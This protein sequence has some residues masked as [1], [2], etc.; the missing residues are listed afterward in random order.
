MTTINKYRIYN[1]STG[2]EEFG[3]AESEPT[4]PFSDSAQTLDPSAT[5]I[6]DTIQRSVVAVREDYKD[7]GG[8]YEIEGYSLTVPGNSTGTIS[9][10]MPYST[11][12]CDIT[13]ATDAT[14]SGDVLNIYTDDTVVGTLAS[15][16]SIGATT[17]IVSPTVLQNVV[18]GFYISLI[19]GAT[20]EGPVR[21]INVD[22]DT[23]TLTLA[24][25]LAN[26]Y[27][28]A[29]FVSL[30]VY[31]AKNYLIGPPMT[32]S[33]GANIAGNVSMPAN[34]ISVATYH[35]NGSESKTIYFNL[36]RLY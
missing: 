5:R 16:A 9:Y 17:I 32:H 31:F 24:S 19:E 35:N 33:L 28:T 29:A 36:Q 18:R 13:F 10:S 1:L 23:S 30:R 20:T 27:T 15:D 21:V 12:T 11:V 6:V 2:Q 25:P 3:W 22:I 7:T 14:M 4:V 8:F 34:Q 26:N